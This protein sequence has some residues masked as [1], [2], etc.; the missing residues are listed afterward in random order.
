MFLCWDPAYCP[1][2]CRVGVFQEASGNSHQDSGHEVVSEV[3]CIPSGKRTY[4]REPD[5]KAVIPEMRDQ[6]ANRARGHLCPA[7]RRLGCRH[8]DRIPRYVREAVTPYTP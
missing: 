5:I 4:L 2:C 7:R 8:R 6:V 3:A 1:T